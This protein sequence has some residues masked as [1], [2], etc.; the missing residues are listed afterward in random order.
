VVIAVTDYGLGIPPAEQSRIFD[1]FYRAAVPENARIA[2]AG[3]GLAL[4][5]HI[6]KAHGGLVRLHSSPGEGSTFAIHLP[7]ASA[8][9]GAA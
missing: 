2:G 6:V 1:R 3:L 5:D 8:D 4:V 7:L 9:Q